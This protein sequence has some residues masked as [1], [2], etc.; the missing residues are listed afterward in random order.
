MPFFKIIDCIISGTYKKKKN[1]LLLHATFIRQ[2]LVISIRG[3][4]SCF[5]DHTI[6]HWTLSLAWMWIAA[7]KYRHSYCFLI[8]YQLC[9]RFRVRAAY[10]VGDPLISTSNPPATHSSATKPRYWRSPRL[11]ESII[12]HL[13]RLKYLRFN[14]SYDASRPL[15]FLSF[16]PSQNFIALP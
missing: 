16:H 15:G 1:Y 13:P 12:E 14:L 2:D 11:L 5:Q 10:Y 4:V 9:A 7:R 3:I 6:S 8:R